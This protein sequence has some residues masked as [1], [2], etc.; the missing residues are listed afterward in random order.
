MTRVMIS[1]A[2]LPLS[3]WH[4]A[5]RG[6]VQKKNRIPHAG[7]E[8]KSPYELWHGKPFD[9]KHFHVFGAVAYAKVPDEKRHKLDPKAKTS[10]FVGY[11][12]NQYGYLLYNNE[13]NKLS[14]V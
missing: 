1:E 7:V 5:L 13:T 2:N 12:T 11:G 10:M 6:A 3:I 9:A 4:V 14:F 8:G